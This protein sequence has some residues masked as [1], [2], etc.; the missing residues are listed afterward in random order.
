[1]HAVSHDKVIIKLPFANTSIGEMTLFTVEMAYV[2]EFL[3]N[4]A[5]HGPSEPV[6]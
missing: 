2:I 4:R 1:M 5:R 3:Q 6:I